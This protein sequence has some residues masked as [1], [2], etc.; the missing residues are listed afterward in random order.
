MP[1]LDGFAVAQE[2]KHDPALAGATIMMLTSA[3]RP[4]DLARCREL[5]IA[6]Y[7]RKPVKQSEL[8]NAVLLALGKLAEPVTAP[9][10]LGVSATGGP[11]GLRILVAED[12]EFNQELVV[13]LLKKQGHVA[14]LADN[15]KAALD[16]WER[17]PFDLILMDVQMPGMDGF[18]V[19]Q[20]IRA[21]EKVTNTHVP[22]IA[23]TAHAM[24]GD[25]ERCLEAGM[26]SYV[27]KP[28]QAAQLLAEIDRL[29]PTDISRPRHPT[30]D[31]D[32]AE[33][34]DRAAL[35]ERL[36]GDFE[37]LDELVETF[38]AECPRLLSETRL[39]V[40]MGDGPGLVRAAHALKGSVSNF[41]APEAFEA[42]RRLEQMGREG[43]LTRAGVAL[44]ALEGE[45]DRFQAALAA[46]SAD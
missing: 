22:I 3:D 23:L 13:K 30:G 41:C 40:S 6:A 21:K 20:A 28:I 10:P 7:L 26:D 34:F 42:A 31:A 8:L 17:A 43:D 44:I 45:V 18:A 37:L 2:I 4:G 25:R 9:G 46:A 11:R 36:D 29:I 19:T 15:G 33:I 16:A 32:T 1:D 39:A 5:G 24:K 27:S 12:N 38:R 35:L 14:V